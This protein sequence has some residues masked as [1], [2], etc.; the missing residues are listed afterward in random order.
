MSGGR[1]AGAGSAPSSPTPGS[2]AG[3]G[4]LP[5]GVGAPPKNPLSGGP[6]TP[7][8][9]MSDK[10]TTPDAG[11]VR[12]DPADWRTWWQFNSEAYIDLKTLL[13]QLDRVTPG[14][15]LGKDSRK[16]TQKT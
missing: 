4:T 13:N 12:S 7:L 6:N 11:S 2:G 5:G 1:G 15:D 8:S 16:L 3:R 14:E 9:P 10:P